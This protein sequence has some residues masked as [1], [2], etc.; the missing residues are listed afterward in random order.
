MITVNKES[1]FEEV[2]ELEKTKKIDI[3][4]FENLYK[5][6]EKRSIDV[7][8]RDLCS[9]IASDLFGSYGEPLLPWSFIQSEVAKVLMCCYY[10]IRDK[11]YTVAELAELIGCTRQGI[12]YDINAGKLKSDKRAKFDLLYESD[13][14]DYLKIKGLGTIE[15]LESKKYKE[16]EEKFVIAKFEREESYRY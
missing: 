12:F 8:V 9:K 16:Q 1:F 10:G 7:N 13:I 4:D 15:E 2:K 11:V 3:S 6:Y 14:N 5:A